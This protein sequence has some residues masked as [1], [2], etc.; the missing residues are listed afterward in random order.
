VIIKKIRCRHAPEDLA[1]QIS[2]KLSGTAF[3]INDVASTMSCCRRASRAA[4]MESF[5]WVKR[6]KVN[7]Y[8]SVISQTAGQLLV[9][10]D[11]RH[12]ERTG[13]LRPGPAR[14]RAREHG[15]GVTNVNV[16][17]AAPSSGATSFGGN[18]FTEA[19]QREFNLSFRQAERLKRGGGDRGT[20]DA[21]RST[22]VGDMASE[23]QKTFDFFAASS[24]GPVDELFSPAAVRDPNPAGPARP[25]RCAGRSDGSAARCSSASRL[26]PG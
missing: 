21:A 25:L 3:D 14:C 13:Q 11:L 22:G 9:D 7:D 26:R 2:G 5:S 24:E 19:L 16:W 8:V 15:A 10:V 23:L 6:D 17:R 12:P 18:Q 4:N 20:A 1:E